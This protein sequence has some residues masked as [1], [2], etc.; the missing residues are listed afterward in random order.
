[1]PVGFGPGGRQHVSPAQTCRHPEVVF[2]DKTFGRWSFLTINW[3]RWSIL[4][5]ILAG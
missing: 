1:V 5:K 4:S 2:F 3:G